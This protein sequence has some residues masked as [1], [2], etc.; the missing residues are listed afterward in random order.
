MVEALK[1]IE[2][3]P[4]SVIADNYLPGTL[5]AASRG[6]WN[7]DAM[8]RFS[9]WDDEEHCPEFPFLVAARKTEYS[10]GVHKACMNTACESTR[11]SFVLSCLLTLPFRMCVFFSREDTCSQRRCAFGGHG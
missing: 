9:G 8:M 1:K 11:H 5:A 6:E 2:H 4:E 3:M 10:F 7:A